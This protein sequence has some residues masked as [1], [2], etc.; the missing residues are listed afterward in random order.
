M[1]PCFDLCAG[2][3]GRRSRIPFHLAPVPG[4]FVENTSLGSALLLNWTSTLINT[5]STSP[6]QINT[7][8]VAQ[9]HSLVSKTKAQQNPM[10]RS[11]GYQCRLW[12]HANDKSL[13]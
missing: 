12:P 5:G 8:A 4:E 6:V 13:L 11:G 9:A 2:T 7:A 1:A 10:M 3:P